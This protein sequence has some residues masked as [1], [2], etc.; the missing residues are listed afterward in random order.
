MRILYSGTP[1]TWSNLNWPKTRQ[2]SLDHYSYNFFYK[3]VFQTLIVR[4]LFSVNLSEKRTP[5]FGHLPD[6]QILALHCT[7]PKKFVIL[8][9]NLIFY[10]LQMHKELI[11]N[12]ILI[13]Q[14]E[15]EKKKSKKFIKRN[16]YYS[17]LFII[18]LLAENRI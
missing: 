18:L 6:V 11:Q 4:F 8:Y 12:C 17:F 9:K 10:C 15:E 2:T 16:L 1:K 3:M 14:W 13:L 7:S 5:G